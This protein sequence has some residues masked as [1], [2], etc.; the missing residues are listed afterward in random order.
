[1]ASRWLPKM[2]LL[3]AFALLSAATVQA[4]LSRFDYTI[5]PHPSDPG[6]PNEY[7]APE[8]GEIPATPSVGLTPVLGEKLRIVQIKMVRRCLS[9][10]GSCL[11]EFRTVF[12]HLMRS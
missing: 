4:A 8:V 3:V 10:G 12:S 5:L 2:V 6:L 1:M 7:T 9:A 11:F